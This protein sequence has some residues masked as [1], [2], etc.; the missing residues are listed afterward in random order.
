MLFNFSDFKL[1]KHNRVEIPTVI[2]ATPNKVLLGALGVFSQAPQFELKLNDISTVEFE[3]PA[4]FYDDDGKRKDT[5]LYDSVVGKML[6]KIDPIGFFRITNPTIVN[7]GLAEKKVVTATFQKL[8]RAE[9][10]QIV[11]KRINSFLLG[12]LAP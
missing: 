8:S 11:E 1:D 7:D 3:I 6:L 4:F 5:P 9:P 12:A 10:W 2:L